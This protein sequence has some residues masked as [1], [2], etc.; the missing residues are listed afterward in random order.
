MGQPDQPRL[1]F[2]KGAS[3]REFLH[4]DRRLSYPTT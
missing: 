3:V 2:A 1:D 4:G